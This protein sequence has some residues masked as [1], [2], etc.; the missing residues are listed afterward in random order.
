MAAAA[1]EMRDRRRATVAGIA[2]LLLR[3]RGTRGFGFFDVVDVF[4]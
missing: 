1:T 2:A 4:S 3:L